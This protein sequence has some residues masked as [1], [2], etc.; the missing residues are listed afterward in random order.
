MAE[1]V[2]VG[3]E[4]FVSLDAIAEARIV[5]ENTVDVTFVGGVFKRYEQAEGLVYALRRRQTESINPGQQKSDEYRRRYQNR[6]AKRKREWAS[7]V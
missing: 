5:D 3:L 1:F 6:V 7:H 2:D 4:E